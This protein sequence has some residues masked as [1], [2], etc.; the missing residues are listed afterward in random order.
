MHWLQPIL[1]L[2]IPHFTQQ[3]EKAKNSLSVQNY[4]EEYSGY[5]PQTS[6]FVLGND[7]DHIQVP[8]QKIRDNSTIPL[9]SP[10]SDSPHSL[11][12]CFLLIHKPF[13]LKHQLHDKSV[14]AHYQAGFSMHPFLLYPVKRCYMT[15][16]VK[17]SLN[18]PH[19]VFSVRVKLNVVI[20]L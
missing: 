14:C 4:Q 18:H 2:F 13:I 5:R 12:F 20:S 17:Q 11:Y 10:H 9:L 6:I 15:L 19:L 16:F 8:L 7:S 3:T 1:Q